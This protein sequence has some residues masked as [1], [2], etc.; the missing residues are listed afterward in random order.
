MKIYID[1]FRISYYIPTICNWP[2]MKQKLLKHRSYIYSEIYFHSTC[3]IGVISTVECTCS[4]KLKLSVFGLFWLAQ[5]HIFLMQALITQ[6]RIHCRYKFKDS[7]NLVHSFAIR[8]RNARAEVDRRS[9][10]SEL[11]IK[12]YSTNS[13][14][15]DHVQIFQN[16]LHH[17]VNK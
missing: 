10:F 7:F 16:I 13:F 9:T 8:K 3:F 2:K 14:L 1:S 17:H 6:C 15:T 11:R 4:K 12:A 5:K